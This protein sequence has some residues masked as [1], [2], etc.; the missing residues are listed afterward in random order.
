VNLSEFC[1]RRPVFTTLL[2][3]SLLVAGLAGYRALPISAL[4]N[5]D[6]PTIS[7]SA[8]LPGASPATMAS[9]VATPL[10]K[11]FS[12]IA[13]ISSMT[14][15]SYLGSTSITL[16]FDLSRNIDGA[17]LDVQTAISTALRRLPKEMTTP[18]SFRKVNPADAP[19]LFLAVSSDS[20][21][22]S[23]VDE[24]A[25]TLMAQRISMVPGVAQA[26]IFGEKKY[27]V[28]IQVNPDK[29]AAQ[30]LGFNQVQQAVAAAASNTPVGTIYGSQQLFNIEVGGQPKDAAAFRSLIAVWKNG[31]PV[32][33]GDIATVLDAVEDVHQAGFLNGKPAIVIAIQRQPGANTIDVVKRVR[34]L[35]PVFRSQMPPSVEI[36]P[37]MDRSVAVGRS[38]HD[39][40]ITL[41]ITFALVVIVIFAFLRSARA[42]LIPALAVPL[43]I[44]ATFGGMELLG[45][46]M[47]N[48]SLL[49]LTLCVGFV[50]DDAIV[51]LENIVRHIEN[52]E[53]PFEAAL[54]GAREIGFT[55]VSMTVSLIAVFIP[56]LFMG[57][58]VGRLFREF[59]LT[60]S[61]AIMFSGLIALTL[62]PML[63]ARLLR[64]HHEEGRASRALEAVF[65]RL[66]AGYEHSLRF[67]LR[68]R[69]LVLLATFA[70]LAGSVMAFIAAPKGFFPQEDTGFIS[71][72]TEGA[73][74]ISYDAML[75]KQKQVAAAI[76][77]HPAIDR[78][79][80]SLGGG[81]G[82]LNEGRLF[83]GL[84]QG[85]RDSVFAV[86]Q[87]LRR[88]L[89]KIPGVKAYLQPV[90]NIQIG[91]MQSKSL[92]Q[93]TLQT[94]DLD[95]LN[96]W[97]EKLK[98]A[99]A[100]EPGFQDVTSDLQL[101][102]LQAVVTVDQQK[103]ASAGITYDDIRQALYAAFGTQQ[104]GSLYTASN[105]Y[106]V[107]FEVAPQ[108]QKSIADIGSIYVSGADKHVVPLS[109]VAT[110]ARGQAALSVN[111]L[112]Q[113]PSVTVSFNLAPGI[114]L[115]DAVARIEKIADGIG[116]PD[117]ITG[118]FQG[119]AQAFQQSL[120][121]QGIL[122]MFAIVV[123]YVILG[124][125]YE[126]FIHPVTIISGLP[127]AML[128]AILILWLF[129]ARQDNN[130][131]DI[132]VISTIGIVLLIGIVKKNS[133][134]MV[135]F[136]IAE[137]AKGVAAE[138]AIFQ[139]C[140]L[141]FRPIMMTTMAAIFGSLP[142]A[143]GLGA[144]SE[145]RQ[146][147]GIAVV[148]GLCVSQLLTLYITPVVY[149]YL[150]KLQ[151]RFSPAAREPAA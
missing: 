80:S 144:G 113:L 130:G 56:V 11:Q 36:T 71:G 139:A 41:L 58:I 68:L 32:R 69:F 119:N 106:Q 48:I 135:D 1:I 35:L 123:I 45:F 2:M 42:T 19:V 25:D 15:T 27:A 38:V 72:R 95:E 40:E 20:L 114:S 137:R 143:V 24:Y 111:H 44:V 87:K 92:Y 64:P 78:V 33:L 65:R 129:H 91:G 29:L 83:I 88:D 141:R 121:G 120:A 73:Q 59:A 13:G 127:S 124:M 134:M 39:V 18:P 90:Q 26:S 75:E 17:A 105:S 5:V 131:M 7:V 145:L 132:N 63:C 77:S 49:A 151:N 16:Q 55:I 128:G 136:A 89:A 46:S 21:P 112:G 125:L 102:S 84:K 126:S 52:G 30:G 148:G 12:T 133:I 66:L 8:S 76:Q 138:E 94:N 51:M 23:Q 6:F 99:L 93:Y 57:G 9:S 61:M 98:D 60:I 108:Y 110:V 10:E 142:I 96:A 101:K 79:F 118:S 122:L 115:G 104:A 31:A 117:S 100:K 147:L 28:R 140:V 47:N 146:P 109:A 74:D 81:R 107:I 150:E 82:A 14:S 53:K 86:I 70:L 3:A 149:L 67:M 50:V 97:S 43:S 37:M 54:K 62:T 103:A 116:M 34:A 4:P 85:D 22:L